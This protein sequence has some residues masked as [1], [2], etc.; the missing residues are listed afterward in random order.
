MPKKLPGP[1]TQAS[2]GS[3]TSMGHRP[4]LGNLSRQMHSPI[5]STNT[6]GSRFWAHGDDSTQSPLPMMEE[7]HG[8]MERGEVCFCREYLGTA[9]D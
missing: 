6:Y 5:H 3:V 4:H 7:K 1:T 8:Q 9:G 2:M